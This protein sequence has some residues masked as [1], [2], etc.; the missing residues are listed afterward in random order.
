MS[1]KV[2]LAACP[3]GLFLF[4]GTLGFKTEYGMTLPETPFEPHRRWYVSDWPEAYV[5]ES[6]E[7]FWGGVTGHAE[8]AA[9]MV[10]PVGIDRFHAAEGESHDA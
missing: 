6:G 1:E 5:V 7:C 8:R 10:E 3:P 4:N 2:T 9:L